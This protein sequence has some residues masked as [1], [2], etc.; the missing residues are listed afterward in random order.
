MSVPVLTAVGDPRWEADLSS[1]LS[2]DEQGLAVVRRCV[3]LADLLS[4]AAAG[5]ARAVILSADLRRLDRE[6]LSRLTLS[7]V[8]VVGLID[9]ADESA[10]RRLRQLGVTHVLP[11]DASSTQVSAAVLSAIA[12]LSL[13]SATDSSLD[14]SGIGNV[15][16]LAPMTGGVAPEDNVELGAGRVVAVWGPI[17]S[18]GR[19]TIAVNLA[20][21]LAALGR[22]TL[23]VDADTYGGVV[24]QLLGVLD[25]APGLAA[26]C[27][28]ANNG[29]LDATSLAGVALELR[30]SLR[31]LTGITRADRWLEIRPSALRTVLGLARSL[32]AFTVIDCGFCLEQDEELA[33]DTAAPRRNGA[34]LAALEAADDIVAVAAAD[35]VGL[36][37]YIRAFPQCCAIAPGRAPQTVVNR[38]RHG[39]V[40]PGEPRR[41][42]AAALQRYAGVTSIQAVPDD[43]AGVDAA[44]AAGR[45]LGEVAP[46]SVA[47]QA[48]RTIAARLAGAPDP[49]RRRRQ[50]LRASSG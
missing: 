34:T 24:A 26:A 9:P 14:W 45:T 8:A 43:A 29:S 33:Y 25:E 40:G 27:R 15:V 47:R 16:E 44:L 12:D 50:R 36:A 30:P 11:H 39:V 28:L 41:E 23:L 2:R 37:R 46:N 21:E 49:A 4:A 38:L 31:V 42:V 10:D 22:S 1:G 48:I 7:G 32:A 19:S 18:P 20:A 3:D 17:G 35:P 5:L 6:A 13:A